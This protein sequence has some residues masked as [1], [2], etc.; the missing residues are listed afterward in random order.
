MILPDMDTDIPIRPLMKLICFLIANANIT[1]NEFKKKIIL[2][3]RFFKQKE[4]KEM[5]EMLKTLTK[6]AEVERIIE[7]YGQGFDSI[8]FDGKADGINE[9][10]IEI[11]RNLLNYGSDIEFIAR[12]TGLSIDKV[13]NLKREL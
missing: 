12:N 2:C 4:L 9:A 7:K 3:E 1:D 5:V 11:A 13:K 6:N 8:Y 10:K